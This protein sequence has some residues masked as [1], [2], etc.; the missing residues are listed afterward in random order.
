VK[1]IGIIATLDT[2]SEEAACLKSLIQ[3][4][5]H[6][7]LLVDLGTGR[8]PLLQADITAAEVAAAAG[9]DIVELRTS[10]D[11]GAVSETMIAGAIAALSPLWRTDQLEAVISV[12]G[13]SSAIMASAIMRE[14]PYRIPKLIFSSGASLE[15]SHRWFGPTGV[16]VMHCLVD[17]GGLNRLLEEQLA[18][19]AGAICGMAESRASMLVSREQKP[20]VAMSTNSWVE[21][22]G[23]LISQRLAREYE[24][25]HFHATG[26]SEVFM[27][28]LVE[29]DYFEAVID[30]VPS[31]ITNQIFGGARISWPRR[32]EVAGERGVPQVVGPCLVN[33]ISRFRES[34]EATEDMRVR[35]HY[36]I[37]RQ[38]VLLWLTPQEVR[39][40]ALVYA[41]RLNRATGPTKLLVPTKGWLTIETEDSEFYDPETV[42]G[43][44]EVMRKKLKPDIEIREVDANINS[45]AFA[46]AVVAAFG[47]VTGWREG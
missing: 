47:E 30:L 42:S 45:P 39:E 19:A 10:D 16:T 21:T 26:Q 17:V 22:S 15:G 40:V 25:I 8:E 20:A 11:R 28:K 35:K 37:D 18:I 23:G 5:E 3:D 29:E 7:V 43:F 1:K 13:A 44:I 33:V 2:K 27:E 38:R 41:E 46:E 12:G 34:P 32:L 14:I 24:V 9:A 4:L 6:E 31:S 36:F